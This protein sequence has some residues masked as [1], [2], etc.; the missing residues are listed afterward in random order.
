MAT[1]KDVAKMAGVSVSTVSRIINK[2]LNF[3]DAI[4]KKVTSAIE[5]LDYHPNEIAR[6]LQQRRSYIIGLIV[7]STENPYWGQI[8]RHIERRAY[9]LGY[10]LLICNSLHEKEKEREYIN[11]L[12]R[13][14]V[15][16]II[17]AS[18]I[19]NIKSYLKLDLPLVS[20]DRQ[21]GPRIPYICSDNDGGGVLAAEH[22]ISR[23][24]RRIICIGGDMRIPK[25][26]N[27][28]MDSFMETCRTG[29]IPC[30]LYELSDKFTV[31]FNE[32]ASIREILGGNPDC[33]GIFA[34][35][36]LI[37][38]AVI[39]VAAELG[40]KI[41]GDIKLIGF[42]DE[43]FSVML[44]PPLTTVRQPIEHISAYA[45][46]HLVKMI[47]GK[48]VPGQV[49]LPVELIERKSTN[50]DPS[51]DGTQSFA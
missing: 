5:Q 38:M 40:R 28:R 20:L 18:H 31:D 15:D 26:S 42:D 34:G 37:A 47:D 13:N 3:S 16:G 19:V 27:R 10:K 24:C 33:D 4:T 22:L 36:D 41:P 43:F 8:A 32:E 14:Q 23:G 39:G 25:L 48:V 11:M 35:N 30:R 2:K 9:E 7:P 6:S 12:K 51:P 29:G 50:A 44:N 49:I 21:L 45:V 17:M 1:L 46:E